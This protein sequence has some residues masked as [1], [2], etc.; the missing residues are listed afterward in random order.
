MKGFITDFVSNQSFIESFISEKGYSCDH[1]YWHNVN[2]SED[3]IYPVM[4]ITDKG[5][6]IFSLFYKGDNDYE[7]LS[8]VLASEPRRKEV[9]YEFAG[10]IFGGGAKKFFINTSPELRGEI[11]KDGLFVVSKVLRSFESP[12]FNLDS[13]DFSLPGKGWKKV[14]NHINSL[15]KNHSIDVKDCRAVD[16]DALLC[17]V[18]AWSKARK[19]LVSKAWAPYFRNF[20]IDGELRNPYN[21]IYLVFN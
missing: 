20:I 8:A 19:S 21:F 13:F 11:Q 15:E 10:E 18:D 3:G 9:I 7:Q 4:Y 17:V 16:K 5:E 14:R 2:M 1:N 12:V 6:G